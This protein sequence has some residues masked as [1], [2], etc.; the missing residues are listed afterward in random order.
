MPWL[1]ST[2]TNW[3][4]TG[5]H[6]IFHHP[7]PLCPSLPEEIRGHSP[8]RAAARERRHLCWTTRPF[9]QWDQRTALK[10]VLAR[11]TE[12]APFTPPGPRCPPR[13]SP[14]GSRSPAPSR[15]SSV[16]QSLPQPRGSGATCRRRPLLP[17]A[18]MPGTG[19]PRRFAFAVGCGTMSSSC[20]LTRRSDLWTPHSF[21]STSAAQR[22]CSEQYRVSWNSSSSLNGRF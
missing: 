8:P 19:R 16:Q 12:R 4:A 10:T 15:R 9:P 3:K 22:G 18:A 14:R 20:L 5:S 11:C 21:S 17:C 2:S 13:P 7:F 1:H 6:S